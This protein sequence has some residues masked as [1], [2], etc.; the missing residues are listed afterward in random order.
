MNKNKFIFAQDNGHGMD[1]F[2]FRDPNNLEKIIYGKVISAFAEAPADTEDMP[3]FEGK[4]YYV[5]DIALMEDSSKII[6]IE[7]YKNLEFFAPLSLWNVWNE[8]EINPESIDCL[9]I[10]LSL[11][12]KQHAKDFIKRLSKFKIN[13]KVYNFQNK[14]VLVPQ[15][16]G[17]KYA[18]D[19]YYYNGS[20]TETYAVIDIGQLTVDIATVFNGK[21]RKENAAG[22]ANEGIIKIIRELKEYI[23]VEIGEAISLKEAQ[24]ALIKK[25]IFLY[26]KKIN[27][28]KKI[29]ELSE[30]YTKYI[31]S[32]LEDR[33]KNIFKKF[34]KIYFV[35][36]GAYYIDTKIGADKIGLNKEMLVIPEKPGP[37]F[38]NAIGYLLLAEEKCK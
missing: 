23:T 2:A 4:K 1:K 25:E 32:L 9:A 21:V 10:G 30:A 31:F 16:I 5:G 19:H 7:D 35:G 12:Q 20:N 17:A 14:I 38:F 28:S 37:E 6:T 33:N 11:A 15:G 18:I 3:F 8:K 22:T 34:S 24:N 13:N 26:G 29:E 27:L 36:G